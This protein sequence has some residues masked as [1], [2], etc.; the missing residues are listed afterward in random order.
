MAQPEMT[1][2]LEIRPSVPADVP[3][4]EAIYREAFP[5]E[6]LLPLLNELLRAAKGVLSLAGLRD[7]MV[8]GHVAFT[9]CA[10]EGC[11]CQVALLGP[12]AVAGDARG[13]G[14]GRALVEAGLACLGGAGMARV[15]VLGDPGYYARLG[16]A[17][18]TEV[19]PPFPLVEEWRSA[20]LS[21]RLCAG[22][23]PCRG[24]LAVPLPWRDA[25]LWSP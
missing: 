21:R 9:T 15:L 22:R 8:A 2:T 5:Q 12:L 20:W 17:V 10:V 13:Q 18:E 19:E 11:H 7:A 23:L 6:D 3:L 1:A 24:R 16:F 4:L 14:L 25:R